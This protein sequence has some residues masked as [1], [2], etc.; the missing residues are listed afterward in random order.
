M[1]HLGSTSE[2]VKSTMMMLAYSTKADSM[3]TD[4]MQNMTE[5]VKGQV[6]VLRRR[7]RAAGS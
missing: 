6:Q 2:P 4:A 1:N 7:P 3:G 5:C